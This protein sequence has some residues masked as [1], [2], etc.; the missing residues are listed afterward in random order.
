MNQRLQHRIIN[1]SSEF[2]VSG[3]FIVE[4]N[5]GQKSWPKH[6]KSPWPAFPICLRVQYFASAQEM[7]YRS[8]LDSH[9]MHC[10]RFHGLKS[11]GPRLRCPSLLY[12]LREIKHCLFEQ[13]HSF[14]IIC[15][16][17]LF[18]GLGDYHRIE[19]V[20]WHVNHTVVG[21]VICSGKFFACLQNLNQFDALGH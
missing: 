15:K 16:Y 3:Q 2:L 20:E 19:F 4:L 11:H 10:L 9:T 5:R 6:T 21:L 8:C 7:P 1:R 18:V 12:M 14:S 17:F 13:C